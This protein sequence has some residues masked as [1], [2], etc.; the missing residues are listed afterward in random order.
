MFKYLTNAI[1]SAIGFSKT[2]SRG[3]LVLIF[4]ILIAL[5][6][7]R[8]RISYLRNQPVIAADST[9]YEWI[10]KV[11][12]SYT[13]KEETPQN[14]DEAS[15]SPSKKMDVGLPKAPTKHIL[16]RE[17]AKKEPIILK[18]LNTATAVQ[19]TKGKGDRTSVFRSYY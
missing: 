10:K 8:A 1:S 9:T 6:S 5:V 12:A 4:I 11:Q 16:K 15:V 3:T 19:T 2:E 18:D 13:I 7:S 14:F 17:T